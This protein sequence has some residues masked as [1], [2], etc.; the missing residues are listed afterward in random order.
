MSTE[1]ICFGDGLKIRNPN[2]RANSVGKADAPQ[3]VLKP[4]VRV[5]GLEY[6]IHFQRHHARIALLIGFFQPWERLIFL[7]PGP[8]TSLKN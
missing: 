6:R 5:Q 7:P 8:R 3:Q 1:P 4:G 2:N